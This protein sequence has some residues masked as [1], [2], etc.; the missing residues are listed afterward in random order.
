M[1]VFIVYQTHRRNTHGVGGHRDQCWA[2]CTAPASQWRKGRWTLPLP[3]CHRCRPLRP[4]SA[5]PCLASPKAPCGAFA[6]VRS[7]QH[8]SGAEASHSNAHLTLPHTHTRP[9]RHGPVERLLVHG[10]A[11]APAG[12]CALPG[13]RSRR[14]LHADVRHWCLDALCHDVHGAALE[15]SHR[16]L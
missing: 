3:A 15:P 16:G 5:T 1:C 6:Q 9:Y 11:S 12:H 7:T 8:Q 4:A 2:D 10:H 13:A 14:L